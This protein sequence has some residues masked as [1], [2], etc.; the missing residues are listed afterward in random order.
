MDAANSLIVGA[1]EWPT[2]A[3]REVQLENPRRRRPRLCQAPQ[4]GKCPGQ[5]HRGYAS[6]GICPDGF[7]GHGGRIIRGDR[8][9]N[10]RQ[11]LAADQVETGEAAC[12]EGLAVGPA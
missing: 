11:V 3:G 1:E 9:E 10:S 2:A 7:V 6:G 5:L 12:W 4:F 8:Y